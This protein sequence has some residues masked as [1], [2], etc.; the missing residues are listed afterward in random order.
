LP[1]MTQERQRGQPRRFLIDSCG[2]RT[3]P[4]AYRPWEWLVQGRGC[5]VQYPDLGRGREVRTY[6]ARPALA[7][8]LTHCLGQT[9]WGAHARFAVGIEQ[10]IGPLPWCAT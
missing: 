3:P 10:G 2:V 6:G 5:D 8:R 9:N 1:D 7:L 4:G